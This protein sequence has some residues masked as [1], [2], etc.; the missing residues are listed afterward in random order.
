MKKAILTGLMLLS[1][2]AVFANGDSAGLTGILNVNDTVKVKNF[3]YPDKIWTLY[4]PNDPAD[5]AKILAYVTYKKVGTHK[6]T[7]EYFDQDGKRRDYCSF[8]TVVTNT[9]YIHTLTCSWGGR[10]P[11]GGLTFKVFNDLNG[12]KEEIGNLFLP[13]KKA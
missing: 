8:E 13:A 12:K 3:I 7:V 10:N 9:P 6:T 4:I 11:E 1:S 2:S 5:A